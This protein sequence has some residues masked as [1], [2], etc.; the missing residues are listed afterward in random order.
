MKRIRW[1]LW[2]GTALLVLAAA[3]RGPRIGQIYGA[4]WDRIAADG[5]TYYRTSVPFYKGSRKGTFLG[6]VTDG[7]ETVFRVYTV[8]GLNDTYRYCLWG[9]EGAIYCSKP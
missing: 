3:C 5:V 9:W 4:E 6:R 2:A 8:P 1:W 7:G